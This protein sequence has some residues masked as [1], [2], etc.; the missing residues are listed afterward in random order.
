MQNIPLYSDKFRK[1]QNCSWRFLLNVQ[2]SFYI[3]LFSPFKIYKVMRQ[4]KFCQSN[5]LND[6]DAKY[7]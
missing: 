2:D 1:W 6:Y 4:I 7:N 5:S 3:K